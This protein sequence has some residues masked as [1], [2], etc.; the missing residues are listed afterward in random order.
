MTTTVFVYGTLK[1]GQGN[2]RL[3]VKHRAEFLGRAVT[4]TPFRM[5]GWGFPWIV[6]AEPTDPAAGYVSGELWRVNAACLE[7]LDA[8]EGN[9]RMY[10]RQLIAVRDEAGRVMHAEGYVWLRNTDDGNAVAPRGDGRVLS[11]PSREAA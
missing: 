2:N 4:T 11:W 10:Q 3:L 6:R 5:W 1:K 8:L 9:G 7:D